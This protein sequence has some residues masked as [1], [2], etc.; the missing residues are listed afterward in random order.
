ME[1]ILRIETCVGEDN[2]FVITSVP[3]TFDGIPPVHRLVLGGSPLH[4][5]PDRIGLAAYL[6]FGCYASGE[7]VLPSAVGP[8]LASA[9]EDDCRPIRVRPGPV[10][11]VPRIMATG[12]QSVA[13]RH[14][15]A[16]SLERN[17]IQIVPGVSARGYFRG[18]DSLTVSSNS[19]AFGSGPRAVL[20]VA[21]L[22]AED[23]S[24]ADLRF[25]TLQPIDD[26][27]EERLRQLLLSVGLGFSWTVTK[28]PDQ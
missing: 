22:F 28:T 4:S 7:F 12:Q 21:V 13:V 19:F 16:V 23:L 5:H 18:D 11:Y 1:I 24:A 6:A 25:D 27:E 26:R 15:R 14:G 9:V 2:G 10:E 20:A 17:R 8:E 3:G